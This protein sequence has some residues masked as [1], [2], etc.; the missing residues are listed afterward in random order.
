MKA[1]KPLVATTAAV[2]VLALAACSG[3][4]GSASGDTGGSA[5]IVWDMWAGSDSDIAA[6]ESSLAIA[7][8]ENPD[9]EISLQ[10]APW[11]DYFTKLT[12]NLSSGNVACITSMNGQRL[13][14]YADAFMELTEADL[15]TAGIDPADFTDGAL[16]IMT[17]DGK[18]LGIP[19]D[20]SAM[21]TYYNKDAFDAAGAAYPE[22]GWTWEEFEAAAAGATT[23]SMK[24]FA[25]GMAEFQWMA[26]PIAVSGTQP[27]TEDGELNL[28]DPAFVEA[29]EQ[30]ASLVEN[31][32]ADPAPSAS[33]TGWGESQYAAGNA[34]MA[35]DGT[36]N[37]VSYINND[38]GF[39]AGMVN[40]PAGDDGATSLVLGSGYGISANCENKEA[41]LQVLGSLVGEAAQDDIAASGR[42]Y[43]ART[44]SQPLYFESIDESIRDEVQAAFDAAFAD[45]EGQRSTDN[46]TQISETFPNNLV[47]VYQGSTSVADMLAATQAQFEN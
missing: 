30:Y 44:S 29:A 35:V 41:A 1:R 24:G 39:A 45:V 28:T 23:D 12:T 14:G 5:E 31:G 47:S 26:I 27:V 25:M 36:W 16:D 34:A 7:Q 40:L 21:L 32:Y 9:V 10:T 13:S 22:N 3:D 15:E 8:E 37:A 43:P 4:S 38:P 17:Y 6:L 20:V 2:A 18:L 46:W 42:S 33:E 19:Y 11:N